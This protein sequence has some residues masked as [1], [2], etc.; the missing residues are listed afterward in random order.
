MTNVLAVAERE[1]RNYFVSPLAYVVIFLF[2]L[3]SGL[4]FQAIL[5]S[6]RQA[7]MDGLLSNVSVLFLL[8]VPLISMR[9]LS[10]E[11]RTG[12]IELM[13]TKPVQ[14]WEVVVGKYLA[15][16][17]LIILM[18]VLSLVY[19]GVLVLFHGNPDGGPVITGYIG[20][21]LQGATFLAVGLW[22]SSLSQNQIVS[23]LIAF[24][25]LLIL[26]LAQPFGGLIPG[27]AGQIFTYLSITNHSQ[28]FTSGV[29]TSQDLIYFF[30]VIGAGLVL[31]TLSLQTRRLS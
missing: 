30:T 2:L 10:E 26:W 22:A 15:S 16:L 29:I 23:A 17:A 11:L 18:L 8:I 5:N 3:P 7:S 13:L 27:V 6:S 9:L 4:L 12:T 31:A 25:L 19:L 14:E 28:Q 20:A 24:V 21:V 1:L